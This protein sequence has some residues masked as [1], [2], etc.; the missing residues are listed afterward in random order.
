MSPFNQFMLSL[1]LL[2]L[3]FIGGTLG[4]IL[5][6]G[7]TAFQAFYMTVITVATVGYREV[8]TMSSG[9]KW[10][11]VGLIVFGV[12]AA[13]YAISSLTAL[14]VG[15]EIQDILKGRKMEANI[16]K[17]KGHFIICGGGVVGKE[18]A[19]EFQRAKVPF[20]VIEHNLEA[21]DMIGTPG[22]LFVEGDATDDETLIRAG[23][24]RAKGLISALRHD[25]DN[26]FV[27]LTARQL[28]SELLI[29]SR[30]SEQ[31]TESKLLRAGADRVVSPY[32]IGGRRMAFAAIRPSVV[33]FLDVLT[34]HDDP[35]RVEDLQV[36]SGS[37]LVGKQIRE[38]P[39]I[40]E[41]T[42]VIVLGIQGLGGLHHVATP[43]EHL[44]ARKINENDIL[45]VLGNDSQINRLRE[46][47][48]G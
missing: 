5:V 37:A 33:D 14:I 9:G 24:G 12:G 43:D 28:N 36:D 20:V 48:Q 6:E 44:A 21:S 46:I 1:G 16:S 19:Q 30:A 27:T 25:P 2:V 13:G 11:T 8:E 3:V 45:I 15:G 32:Q 26:V 31:G 23:V 10:F 18:I 17:L 40:W 35:L 39:N 42:G 47:A 38:T 7:W 41:K 34:G 22:V 4:Y 29:V